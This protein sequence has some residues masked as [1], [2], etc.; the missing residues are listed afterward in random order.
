M[1]E[2]TKMTIHKASKNGKERTAPI[3]KKHIME[4]LQGVS[5]KEHVMAFK[6]MR[7]VSG[8]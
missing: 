6:K 2:E 4:E 3:I 8:S 1:T 5:I 7:I